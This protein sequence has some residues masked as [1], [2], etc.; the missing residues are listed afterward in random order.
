MDSKQLSFDY[1]RRFGLEIEMLSFDKRDFKQNPLDHHAGEIPKGADRVALLLTGKLKTQVDIRKWGHTN[2]NNSWV[3][4]P[5]SSCGIE[6]CSPVLKGWSGIKQICQ[7]VESL[8]T[9]KRCA[10]DDRC[11]LH[12]HVDV[13]D[14]ETDEI[15]KIISY[16]VKCE[17]VFLDSVPASRKRNKYCQ[18]IGQSNHFNTDSTL[19]SERIVTA[20]GQ[21]KYY[22]LN[23]FHMNRPQSKRQTIEFRIAEGAGCLDP[24]HIKNWIRLLI[25]FVER[26][27]ARPRLQAYNPKNPMTSFS[28]LD[29]KDVFE[30]LGFNENLSPGLKQTRD[31]FLARI[32]KNQ[33]DTNLPGIWSNEA[34]Y[35][36]R[37]E[38]L[39][40]AEKYQLQ[41]ITQTLYPADLTEALWAE[42]TK[43]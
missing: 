29:P 42:E 36:A 11:G 39:E 15:A 27:K 2:N 40:L 31:W 23:T 41:D 1:A 10:V 9:E 4:K 20:L 37:K 22:T 34:R 30:F 38:A 24:F 25:H 3:V 33:L 32:L 7:G 16:W 8:L 43:A 26:A 35:Y 17:A 28:W 12:L 6:I 5:D 21:C 13:S 18:P 19:Q 14:C